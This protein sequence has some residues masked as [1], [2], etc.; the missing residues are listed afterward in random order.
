MNNK[1]IISLLVALMLS[2]C[3]SETVNTKYYKLGSVDMNTDAE[4]KNGVNNRE[5]KSNVAKRPLLLIEPILLADFLRQP[6]LVIQKAD[7]QLQISNVHRWAESLESAAL[8]V[9]RIQLEK[10]LPNYRIENQNGRWKT[11]PK[12]RLSIELTQFQIDNNNN[13]VVSTG[14]FWLFD[15]QRN[16]LIKKG[17]D[18]Q[19]PLLKNGYAHAISKLEFSLLKLAE[20]IAKNSNN[21]EG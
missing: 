15:E 14:T 6:G 16:L 10:R 13:Q 1:K 2:S 11:P 4:T 12:R 7:H 5:V 9:L 8:R 21:F 19:Q 3:A 20:I 17:F 18:I